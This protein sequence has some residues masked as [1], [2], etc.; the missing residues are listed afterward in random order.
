MD[1]KNILINQ[2]IREVTVEYDKD[3][4]LCEDDNHRDIAEE[5]YRKQNKLY[6]DLYNLKKEEPAYITF[7]A[8]IR[9]LYNLNK[10]LLEDLYNCDDDELKKQTESH[11]KFFLVLKLRT[12]EHMDD[13]LGNFELTKEPPLHMGYDLHDME[14]NVM[15]EIKQ[16]EADLKKQIHIDNFNDAIDE[17]MEN[18]DEE[19][20]EYKGIFDYNSI[21]Y[22]TLFKENDN[23]KDF[24]IVDHELIFDLS[25]V[26][27]SSSQESTGGRRKRGNRKIK[28]KKTVRKSKRKYST[29]KRRTCVRRR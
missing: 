9:L 1:G 22:T 15:I 14:T 13:F 2:A 29:K 24:D 18:F 8:H 12:I 7:L 6:Y 4:P 20:P 27:G 28:S 25:D 26:S 21:D 5:F 3:E 19:N 17:Y 16:I 10:V 23:I 11:Y